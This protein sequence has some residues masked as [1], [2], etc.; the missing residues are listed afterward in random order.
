[1]GYPRIWRTLD[2]GQSTLVVL[3]GNAEVLM[4]GITRAGKVEK[5]ERWRSKVLQPYI[6]DGERRRQ[7]IEQPKPPAALRDFLYLASKIASALQQP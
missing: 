4:Q 6:F 2:R 3:T 7:L 5:S 1:M